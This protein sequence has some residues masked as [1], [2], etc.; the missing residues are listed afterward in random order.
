MGRGGG[1]GSDYDDPARTAAGLLGA[2]SAPMDHATLQL[3]QGRR[4]RVDGD[5]GRALLS[6][7]PR[8]PDQHRL[9]NEGQTAGLS[10]AVNCNLDS[11]APFLAAHGIRLSSLPTETLF[12]LDRIIGLAR[13]V[14]PA[15]AGSLSTGLL[16][17]LLSLL[18]LIELSEPTAR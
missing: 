2:S 10:G 8:I 9:S 14:V 15:A 16:I 18:F 13:V 3:K 17:F 11:M 7:C 4:N 1:V 6:S 12:S 5:A